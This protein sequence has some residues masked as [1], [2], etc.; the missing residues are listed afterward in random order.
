MPDEPF[1]EKLEQRLT[2]LVDKKLKSIK[3][4]IGK[5]TGR[6][7][8][9]ELMD[10]QNQLNSLDERITKLINHDLQQLKQ[11]HD[12]AVAEQKKELLDM[13]QRLASFMI[14]STM[15]TLSCRYDIPDKLFRQICISA[16]AAKAKAQSS[17]EALK[18]AFEFYNHAIDSL[19]KGGISIIQP[20][21]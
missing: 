11:A 10:F 7:E 21:L 19:N 16:A 14:V 4:Q 6:V 2:Q 17:D 20:T 9:L 8:S 1:E 5:L 3:I 18:V 13:Q 15:N 12:A